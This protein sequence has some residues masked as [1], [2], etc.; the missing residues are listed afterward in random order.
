MIMQLTK[1]IDILLGPQAVSFSKSSFSI[2]LLRDSAYLSKPYALRIFSKDE[3]E[4]NH[5]ETL[6][7]MVQ[8]MM[9]ISSNFLGLGEMLKKANRQKGIRKYADVC[10]K[11]QM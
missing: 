2:C 10:I 7:I 6:P 5:D 11:E 4:C 8:V 3:R 1:K 9:S